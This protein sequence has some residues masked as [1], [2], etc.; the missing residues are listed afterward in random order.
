MGDNAVGWGCLSV[1]LILGVAVW[2]F[3]FDGWHSSVRYSVE[4]GVDLDEVT[5]DKRPH[6]CDWGTAPLGSKYCHYETEI[7]QMITSMSTEGKPIISYDQ[8]KTWRPDN[9]TPPRKSHVTVAWRKVND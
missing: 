4:Y 9:A 3:M 1:I 2:L 5:V 6:D 7:F 8:G